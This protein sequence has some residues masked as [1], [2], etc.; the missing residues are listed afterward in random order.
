MSKL[1]TEL[2]LAASVTADFNVPSDDGVQSYRITAAQIR[3]YILANG[4]VPLAALA[5]AV[6]DALPKTGFVQAYA[7]DTAPA[8][9]LMCDGSAVSRTTYADL[10]AVTGTRHGQGNGSTTFNLPDYKGK[11]LRGRADGSTWDPDRAS[12]IAMASGGATGD[13]VGS[14][15]GHAF[16]THTHVQNQHAHQVVARTGPGASTHGTTS[17]LAAATDSVTSD[18]DASPVYATTA[19]N[20]TAGA[21]GTH[22]QAS[23]N[24]SRPVNAYVNYI[25]K[26]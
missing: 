7:G 22:A 24:E 17:R 5:Q 4:T 20:Q 15:Q 26:I 3:A 2:P 14:V 16:Q 8:G 1:I 13:N 6:Q 21:T 25:I 12:R 9:W 18:Y 19:V 11:F 23:S 10:F